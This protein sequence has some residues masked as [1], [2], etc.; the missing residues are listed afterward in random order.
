MSSPA[1]AET[2]P[3]GRATAD[4]PDKLYFTIGEIGRITGV[5]PHV[6][7]F[8][9]QEFPSLSPRKDDSGRRIYRRRDVELV[10]KIK[11]LLYDEKFTIAGARR[12]LVGEEPEPA[13]PATLEAIRSELKLVLSLLRESR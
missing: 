8:W 12:A 11:H 4:V 1:P 6:L 9:E 7:R 3:G 13:E 5:K 2:N 10:M